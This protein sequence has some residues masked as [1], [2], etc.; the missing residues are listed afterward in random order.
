MDEAQIRSRIF[1]SGTH[2]NQTLVGW[3]KSQLG[4]DGAENANTDAEAA[5]TNS[6][7]VDDKTE[8]AKRLAKETMKELLESKAPWVIFQLQ[9][10]LLLDDEARVNVPGTVG[11]NWT[12]CCT[13][14]LPEVQMPRP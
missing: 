10:I 14:S 4:D 6:E 7:A 8:E 9:D 12:W 11:E 2:D 5:E 1:Y 3:Y 13:E